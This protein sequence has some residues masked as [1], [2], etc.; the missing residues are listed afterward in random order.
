MTAVGFFCI[1]TGVVMIGWWGW[2]SAN[3]A[4]EEPSTKPR[5]IAT[6]VS[7]EAAT[8]AAF[9][10]SGVSLVAHSGHSARVASAF[11]LEEMS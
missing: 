2:A 1:V 3:H 4:V 10:A 5:E 6:H 7:A 8:A 9:V 11:A